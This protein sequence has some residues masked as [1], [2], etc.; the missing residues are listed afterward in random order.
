M[1]RSDEQPVLQA[2][3][4]HPHRR[5]EVRHL[6]TEGTCLRAA[7]AGEFDQAST[8]RV[9]KELFA[10]LPPGCRRVELDMSDVE[11][12]G[13][14]L[15]DLMAELYAD[16]IRVVC[17]GASGINERILSLDA[18]RFLREELPPPG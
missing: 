12:M 8:P 3:D 15:L 6:A 9:R 13:A 14:A 5:A 7:L 18:A 17:T 11:F 1:T 16:R 10:L 2:H 4:P